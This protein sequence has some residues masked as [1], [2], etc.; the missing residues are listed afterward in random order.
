M[1]FSFGNRGSGATTRAIKLAYKTNSTLIVAGS[2]KYVTE[3]ANSMNKP[4]DIL[5]VSQIKKI[6][7]DISNKNIVIDNPR[8]VLKELIGC[9]NIEGLVSSAENSK[10]ECYYG[11]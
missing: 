5:T 3:L 11:D 4:I 1:V 10:I 8:C 6:G 2:K 9:K 7:I